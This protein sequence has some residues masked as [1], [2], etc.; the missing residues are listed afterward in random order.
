[1]KKFGFLLTFTLSLSILFSANLAANTDKKCGHHHTS[2]VDPTGPTGATGISL[3]GATGVTGVTGL[4]GA[5]GI[6]GA[7]GTTTAGSFAFI[8]TIANGLVVPASDSL[9]IGGTSTTSA[10]F[11]FNNLSGDLTVNTA[12][13]YMVTFGASSANNSAFGVSI[14]GGFIPS[15]PTIYTNGAT[16]LSMTTGSFVVNLVAGDTLR[17]RSSSVGGLD[18][19]SADSAA[20]AYLQVVRLF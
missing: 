17:L 16:S 9:L 18:L 20:S 11:T 7:T 10:D 8:S 15:A 19:I 12:G 6:T 4:P 1:M 5:T 3:P 13:L 2:H 14:N